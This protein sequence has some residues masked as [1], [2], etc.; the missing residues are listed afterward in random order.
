[1]EW[2][3][4]LESDKKMIYKGIYGR[5]EPVPAMDRRG[6]NRDNGNYEHFKNIRMAAP[7]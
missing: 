1:M 5:D 2:L 6:I 3:Q 7:K 4:N